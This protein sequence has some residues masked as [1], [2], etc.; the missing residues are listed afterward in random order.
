MLNKKSGLITII[1]CA[2]LILSGCATTPAF[3]TKNITMIVP[4]TAGGPADLMART[5]EKPAYQKFN[6]SLVITNMPGGGGTLAWNELAGANPDGYTLGITTMAL[7]LQPLYGDT[8]YHYATALDPIAQIVSYPVVV[9]ARADQPWQNIN[10]LIQHAQNHPGEIKFSHSGIGASHHLFGEIFA[11]EAGINIVQVP[12]RGDSEALA[13]LL[14]GHTQIAFMG[15]TS[16]KEHVKS[17]S[18]KILAVSSEQRLTDPALA[19]APTFKEQ[20]L[21]LVFQIW[22]G[23][24]APK[25]L[26]PDVKQRL[27]DGF[28]AIAQDPEFRQNV[29]NL[30]LT[31]DY[32]D[33]KQ[34]TVKWIEQNDKMVKFLK[35]SGIADLVKA[36]KN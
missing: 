36:Q 30:G 25:Q 27:A 11:K 5:M 29:E 23:V 1:L 33:S 17:G 34:S 14:G 32:L 12:F 31:V 7:I 8:R 15:P 3:P 4:Y 28:K 20:G 24:G 16:V 6:Q 2:A 13:A 19:S 9:V 26:P 10:D 35:E 18:V 21:N 22:Y